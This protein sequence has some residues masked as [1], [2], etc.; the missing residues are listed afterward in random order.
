MTQNTGNDYNMSL[1]W[2][3]ILGKDEQQNICITI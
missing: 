2:I 3:Q 1:L